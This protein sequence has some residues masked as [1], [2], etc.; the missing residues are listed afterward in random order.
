LGRYGTPI[1]KMLIG[2]DIS[3]FKIDRQH[4]SDYKSMTIHDFIRMAEDGYDLYH[5]IHKLGLPGVEKAF[6][7]LSRLENAIKIIKNTEKSEI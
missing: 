5:I 1:E 3:L 4:W 6:E 7:M 2:A